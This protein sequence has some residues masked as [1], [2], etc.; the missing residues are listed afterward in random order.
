MDTLIV[1]YF[2]RKKYKVL[3]VKVENIV[4]GWARHYQHIL[5][6]N[7][8]NG[9]KFIVTNLHNRHG[10]SIDKLENALSNNLNTC[11]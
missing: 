3:C 6:E 7:I 2:N 1:L 11:F 9:K 10:V 8:T 4:D 5:F